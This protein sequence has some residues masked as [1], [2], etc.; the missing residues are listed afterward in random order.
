MKFGLDATTKNT[1]RDST[2]IGE[3]VV[4][5]D[6]MQRGDRHVIAA[7]GGSGRL[8]RRVINSAGRASV[9]RCWQWS[10]DRFI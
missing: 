6:R 3:A 7:P 4:D 8:A 2:R 9:R 10:H 1:D 5:D